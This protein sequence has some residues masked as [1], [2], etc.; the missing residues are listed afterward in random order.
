MVAT[1]G[2][3]STALLRK[4]MLTEAIQEMKDVVRLEPKS[5]EAHYNLGDLYAK[6]GQM[7]DAID[8]YRAAHEDR[9]RVRED[10]HGE[11][12]RVHRGHRG[13][14]HKGCTGVAQSLVPS[15]LSALR[16]Q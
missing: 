12:S 7:Q 8:E 6:N 13:Q 2:Y 3:L 14:G 4:G 9:P 16:V 5:A 10:T 15:W 11:G 1:H